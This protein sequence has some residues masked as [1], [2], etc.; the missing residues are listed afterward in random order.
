M[1]KSKYDVKR[2][3]YETLADVVI[4]SP[5]PRWFADK[6]SQDLYREAT[7]IN[8]E[9]NPVQWTEHQP[10]AEGQYRSEEFEILGPNYEA[11]ISKLIEE[12]MQVDHD[13]ATGSLEEI[14]QFQKDEHFIRLNY[15]RMIDLADVQLRKYRREKN[16]QPFN[17][18]FEYRKTVRSIL[19]LQTGKST[20]PK[21]V[22][23]QQYRLFKIKERKARTQ[24][25]TKEACA[26]GD[27]AMF[28]RVN[29]IKPEY[30]GKNHPLYVPPNTEKDNRHRSRVKSVTR[31][32]DGTW[33]AE[34]DYEQ[35]HR[36][37]NTDIPQSSKPIRKA[38]PLDYVI[39]DVCRKYKKE[40]EEE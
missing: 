35:Q 6:H 13:N 7:R 18:A 12:K 3:K 37:W 8:R 32:D 10:M 27:K 17:W 40:F 15:W 5:P 19:G 4:E 11:E 24:P 21:T 25:T 1:K 20:L 38:E 28:D 34:I 33:H 14:I 39:D 29:K 36:D 16:L 31:L 23:Q 2:R 26:N 22:E 9:K 30:Q